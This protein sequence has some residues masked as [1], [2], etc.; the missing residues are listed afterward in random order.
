[1][2]LPENLEIGLIRKNVKSAK[3]PKK[4]KQCYEIEPNRAMHKGDNPSFSDEFIKLN[5][6]FPDQFIFGFL[7]KYQSN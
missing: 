4:L 6:F 2:L 7:S 5:F 1:M 3:E